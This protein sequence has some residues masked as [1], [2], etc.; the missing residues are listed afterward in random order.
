MSLLDTG[1]RSELLGD[2]DFYVGFA[3][4]FATA[5]SEEGD[6]LESASA[7][8]VERGEDVGGASACGEGD[9]D[10]VGLAV[11]PDLACEDLFEGVIVAD[12][13]VQSCVGSECNRGVGTAVIAESAGDF[14]RKVR[15]V[16]RAAAIAA[17]KEFAAI[18][19]ARSDG[20][21]GS[22]YGHL[23]CVEAV[24]KRAVFGERLLEWAWHGYCE[25]SES[26]V[27]V[28]A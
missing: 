12:G 7:G 23:E 6:S 3:S 24:E 20:F 19:Q 14:R 4:G 15:A 2:G 26:G 22:G 16:S 11:G 27:S 1:C 17:E 8:F 13:C 28:C 18:A 21:G 5:A 9:E 25:V 10:V